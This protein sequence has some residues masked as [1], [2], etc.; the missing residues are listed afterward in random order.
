MR[1]GNGNAGA[2]TSIEARNPARPPRVERRPRRHPGRPTS[3]PWIGSPLAS[4]P[5]GRPVEVD[6]DAGGPVAAGRQP[7]RPRGEQREAERG[8]R[9]QRRQPAGQRQVLAAAAAQRDPGHPEVGEERR[10]R[11]PAETRT[12]G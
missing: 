4:V 3:S 1:C 12:A 11:S 2:S 5:S 7:V 6:V 8:A 9:P 10:R